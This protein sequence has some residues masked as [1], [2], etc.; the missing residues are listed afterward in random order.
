VS[1]SLYMYKFRTRKRKS[2]ERAQL[3]TTIICR[4]IRRN[5][6]SSRPKCSCARLSRVCWGW[7]FEQKSSDSN[8]IW[9]V[10]VRRTRTWGA[11]ATSL[12]GCTTGRSCSDRAASTSPTTFGVNLL[13]DETKENRITKQTKKQ[14]KKNK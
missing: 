1:E 8:R 4:R 7:L 6:C 12:G 3:L 13:T 9:T 2:R 5:T 14:K 10:A 11:G